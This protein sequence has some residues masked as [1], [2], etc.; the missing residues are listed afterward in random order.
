VL[1]GAIVRQAMAARVR[2]RDAGFA[3]TFRI[4][5]N[6][7]AH[8]MTHRGRARLQELLEATGCE[9]HEL[10]L[11]I[12]ETGVLDDVD[13]AATLLADARAAGMQV[14]LDDF[15]TGFSSLMLLRRLPID[16]VKIDRSFVTGVVANPGDR[17]IVG[18]ILQAGRDLG[19]RVV[20]EGVETEAQADVLREL[21]CDGAQGFLY[22][23]AVP[24]GDLVALARERSTLAAS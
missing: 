3:D 17:A 16:V 23:P 22:A 24:L 8:R 12:T 7:D 5:I 19:L 2:L 11:E 4:W 18:V 14:A 9:P 20:A 1:D 13:A 15:G 6:V 21:G 10:G